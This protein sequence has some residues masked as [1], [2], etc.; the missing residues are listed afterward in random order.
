MADLDLD[1]R[2]RETERIPVRDL[3]A[4]IEIRPPGRPVPPSAGQRWAAGLVALAVAAAAVVF[5]IYVLSRHENPRPA[6]PPSTWSRVPPDEAVFGPHA[7]MDAV[8]SYGRTLVAVGYVDLTYHHG[9]QQGDAAAAMWTSRDGRV[10]HRIPAARLGRGVAYDVVGG[11][12]GF[13]A[14]GQLSTTT[15]VPGSPNV[16]TGVVWTSPDG[17]AWTRLPDDPRVF[18]DSVM[19]AVAANGSGFVAVGERISASDASSAAAWTS[20]DGVTWGRATV[21]TPD[22]PRGEEAAMTDVTVI[23]GRWVAVGF[24][25]GDSMRPEVWT[26]V[27]GSAWTAIPRIDAPPGFGFLRSLTTGP[28]GLVTVGFAEGKVAAKDAALGAWTSPDGLHWQAARTGGGMFEPHT[29]ISRGDVFSIDSVT[30]GPA[31][32]VAV[33]EDR[34]EAAVWTSPDGD[35]WTRTRSARV[36]QSAPSLGGSFVEMRGIT[37]WDAGV[38]AVGFDAQ[39]SVFPTP[40]QGAVWI[41]GPPNPSMAP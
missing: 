12:A 13:V 27:D 1:R 28:G 17:R 34:G 9:H 23:G 39:G 7:E 29:S 18:G 10:W 11:P 26:S 35:S 2:F 36:F 31:G 32:F 38:V 22:L 24:A 16:S 8:A 41:Y 25:R 6:N 19:Q 14:V 20:P 4:E 37:A 33:G 3:W 40:E 30:S 5:V 21:A 15:D